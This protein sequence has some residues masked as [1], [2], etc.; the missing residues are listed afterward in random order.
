VLQASIDRVE[1]KNATIH[2][3]HDKGSSAIEVT[4]QLDDSTMMHMEQ[5]RSV[6]AQSFRQDTP[7]RRIPTAVA[8][9]V[10]VCG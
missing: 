9:A 1:K 10:G 4:S 5:T 2:D 8:V 3:L 7:V 6:A